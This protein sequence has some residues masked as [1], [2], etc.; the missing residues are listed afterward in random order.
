M[1]LKK[2]V[3]VQFLKSLVSSHLRLPLDFRIDLS[4]LTNASYD[5]KSPLV[6][7]KKS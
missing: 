7:K 5:S 2:N 4:K 6:E 3:H 1:Q